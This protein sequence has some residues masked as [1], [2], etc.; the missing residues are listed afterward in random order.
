MLD[1]FTTY[2]TF[3]VHSLVFCNLCIFNFMLDFIIT[4]FM[5]LLIIL[6]DSHSGTGF[7]YE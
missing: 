4:L 6:S 7:S 1:K 2:E 5:D 3:F